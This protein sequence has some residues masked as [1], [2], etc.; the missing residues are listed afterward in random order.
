MFSFPHRHPV[1]YFLEKFIEGRMQTF[2]GLTDHNGDIVFFSSLEYSQGIMET[3]NENW[4]VYYYTLRKIPPDLEQAGRRIVRA[5]NIRKRFFHFEFFRTPD[6]RLVG[7]EVNMR[8]PGGLTTDMFNFANDIDIYY[9][10]ANIILHNRFSASITRPYHCAYIGRKFH[11]AYVHS[12]EEIINRYEG[13]MM[14]HE[15]ISGIFAPALG[16]YGYLVRSPSLEDIR[17]M[18]SFIHEKAV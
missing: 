18:A 6:D 16:N 17:E 10:W 11:F 14:H 5:Y 1:D 2:D 4:D 15:A 12:H 9:E 3:V 8:P 7:L 13:I